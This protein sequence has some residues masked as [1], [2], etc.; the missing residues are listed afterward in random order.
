M[1]CLL[2][3][4][5]HFCSLF[6]LLFLNDQLVVCS[7][8]ELF[9]WYMYFEYFLLC[10]GLHVLN[11]LSKCTSF[12]FQKIFIYF[13]G[14]PVFVQRRGFSRCGEPVCGLCSCGM[15]VQLPCAIWDLS[16]STRDWTCIPALEGR[17]LTTGPPGKNQS[18]NIFW[19]NFCIW[20][21]SGLDVHFFL[22]PAPLVETLILSMELLW[23]PC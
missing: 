19:V 9:F 7:E 8:Y 13:W 10:C 3:F 16:S 23:Y 22:Y 4:F 5:A 20:C 6:V 1:K 17:F 21:E 15:W 11:S 12:N 2:R 18:A 14:H